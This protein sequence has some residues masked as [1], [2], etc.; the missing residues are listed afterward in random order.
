[1]LQKLKGLLV[2][3]WANDN[4]RRVVHT[5]WQTFLAVFVVGASGVASSLLSTHNLSDATTA[6]TALV[7]SAVAAALAAVKALY[8]SRKSA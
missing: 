6:L 1:M 3:I 4:V 5:F 8:V 7:V 2:R